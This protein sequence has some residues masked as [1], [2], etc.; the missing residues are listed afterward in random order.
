MNG[1]QKKVQTN[2]DIMFYTKPQSAY[3]E[4]YR[5]IPINL[6]FTTVDRNLKIIQIT[7]A[8]PSENKTTTSV[9][10]AAAY[11][12]IGKKVLII[13]LD[14]RRPKV[15]RYFKIPNDEGLTTFLIDKTKEDQLIKKTDFGIDVINSGPSVPSP[16]VVLRSEK[17][18]DLLGK[19]KERYDVIILDT[20]PVLLVTDSLIIAPFSDASLFV[21]NQ[22]IS[23][24]QD[25]KE[26]V[27]LLEDNH[28]NLVGVV[29]TGKR[30]GRLYAYT[31]YGYATY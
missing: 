8:V 24:K 3:A 23:R 10:L 28:A 13:D 16:H 5:K 2:F 22:N 4:S 19:L 17:L 14:L 12:E 11:Q 15:H 27:R 29:F 6:A 21:V 20:P 18:Q 30:K 7:S 9:N 26:A 31:K 25:S 1:K